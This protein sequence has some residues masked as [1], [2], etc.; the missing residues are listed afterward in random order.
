[1][2]L[3]YIS[4]LLSLILFSCKKNNNGRDYAYFG[5]E[6]INPNKNFVVLTKDNTVI[7]TIKLDGN[8]RFLH[9]IKNLK[10]GLYAFFHG[11]EMQVVLLEPQDSVLVRLNTLEF[12][13]SM[14]FTGIGDKKNNYFI[15]AFLDNEKEEKNIF[16]YCQL[17]PQDYSRTIDSLHALK[18]QNLKNFN[19]SN[20]N[21]ELFENIALNNINYNY[22]SAKEV[23]PFVHFG[24]NKNELLQSIPDNFYAYRAN[25]SYNDSLL[26]D[27]HYYKTFLRH[28]VNNIALYKH[29]AQDTG[30]GFKRSSICFNKD[31]LEVIDSLIS[32]PSIKNDLLH[33]VTINYLSRSNNANN[34]TELLNAFLSKSTNTENNEKLTQYVQALN[35]L[36][37]DNTIPNTVLLDYGHKPHQLLKL[38]TKPS[39]L[40]FW[41][42]KY[43]NHFIESHI[44]LDELKLKY[45]EVNFIVINVD[46]YA[47]ERSK[48]LLDK[49]KF[50]LVNEFV[51]EQPNASKE[52]FAVQPITKAII[53]DKNKKIVN[54]NA[55]IFS[56]KFEEYLLGAINR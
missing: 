49:H 7:D 42:Q 54:S 37:T 52:L 32:N 18:L 25:I 55:N 34:N 29:T 17:S 20:K 21:S 22:Y 14:V 40:C 15:N 51:F 12:D 19:L 35:K 44:K 9:K 48:Q 36:K 45:P 6:I 46:D 1:M 5:G 47:P 26:K 23:Y 43:N 31:R 24:H 4:I 11:S 28:H 3:L 38:I 41:S 16:K 10:P 39:V 27:Y 8:N 13:E 30:E 53:V 56:V 2:R 50:P 33:H